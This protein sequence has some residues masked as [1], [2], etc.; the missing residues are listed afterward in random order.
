MSKSS[1]AIFT[2]NQNDSSFD[3]YSKRAILKI[4]SKNFPQEFYPIVALFVEDCNYNIKELRS[5]MGR[6]FIV[7]Q[8][9][10]GDKRN[11]LMLRYGDKQLIRKN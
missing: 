3:F 6:L 1:K 4:D 9:S 8:N 10:A 2:T 7:G 5:D 11:E